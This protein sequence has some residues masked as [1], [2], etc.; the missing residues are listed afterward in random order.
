MRELF[1]VRTLHDDKM[2]RT[3]NEKLL[4]SSKEFYDYKKRK[5]NRTNYFKSN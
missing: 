1:D 5:K 2:Q 4:V 3:S